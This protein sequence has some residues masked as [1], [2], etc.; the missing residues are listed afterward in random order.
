[1]TGQAAQTAPEPG[2]LADLASF[3]DEP[4]EEESEELEATAEESTAEDESQGDPET[5][6]TAEQE[7]L[8][9][10]TPDKPA[11][12]RKLKVTVKG[13]NGEEITEEV[14][15]TELVKGY[16]RQADYT[17]KTQALA[18]RENQAVEVFTTKHEE[19]RNHYIQQAE[20]ARSVVAQIA[21]I[22]S[23]EEM[24][25]LASSDP[26]A[27]VTENQRKQTLSTILG[28]LD[29]RI[30]GERQ[31]SEKVAQQ[32]KE[33]AVQAAYQRTWDELSKDGID[34]PSLSKIYGSVTQNYGFNTDELGAVYDPRIVRMMKDATAYRELL[35]KKGEVTKKLSEAPK[36]PTK[37]AAP[38]SER[39]RQELTNK[40]Q[41]GRA[42]L[43]DL[44]SYLN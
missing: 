32:R 2:G 14:P 40:F 19:I 1:M 30:A 5:G 27:W 17:R 25:Q 36:L 28:Q 20:L 3:L 35:S 4:P 13:E 12:E 34:K 10:E 37:Q 18:E 15:E 21:G 38:I 8:T 29:A 16:Q 31:E 9:E 6:E 26:A 39:N 42:K 23:D 11:P 7:E 43:K 22:R 41:S 24:A 33:Q 44:V